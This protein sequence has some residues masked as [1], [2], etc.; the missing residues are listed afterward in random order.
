M[1]F[2]GVIPMSRRLLLRFHGRLTVNMA[3]QG[4][5]EKHASAR[6]TEA[7]AQVARSLHR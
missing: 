7:L 2:W 6:G 4:V 5:L 3:G 1:Q